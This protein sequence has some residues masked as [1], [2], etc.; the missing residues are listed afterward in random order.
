M[1]YS[2]ELYARS[3]YESLGD[4]LDPKLIIKNFWLTVKKNGDESRIDNIV[5]LFESLVVKNSGGKVI[6]IETA[7]PISVS[8]EGKI[9]KLFGNKDIIQKKVNSK[10]VAGI[11]IEIDNEKELDFS[12][13][14][15]F[16][17]MFSKT[18]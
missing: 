18:V 1:R 2:P 7:R 10:L 12:L 4:L 3:L 17:K 16:R 9:K 11:R 15:K 8:M 14:A 5:R 13:A 6:Q